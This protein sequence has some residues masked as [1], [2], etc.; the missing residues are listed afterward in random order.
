[1]QKLSQRNTCKASQA[2]LSLLNEYTWPSSPMDVIF[3]LPNQDIP[4]S[5]YNHLNISNGGI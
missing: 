4:S 2:F 1:M 5:Q 3:F